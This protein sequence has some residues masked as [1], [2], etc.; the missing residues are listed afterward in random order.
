[1]KRYNLYKQK[2]WSRDLRIF[3]IGKQGETKALGTLL[4]QSEMQSPVQAAVQLPA[5]NRMRVS[6][7]S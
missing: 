6:D 7:V 4:L 5:V 1:M 3:K 2:L